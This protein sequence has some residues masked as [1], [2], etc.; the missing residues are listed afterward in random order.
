MDLLPG[1]LAAALGMACGRFLEVWGTT[2]DP[3]DAQDVAALAGLLEQEIASALSEA[4]EQE[5]ER[6]TG[7]W[8]TEFSDAMTRTIDEAST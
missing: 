4:I 5:V 6:R 8:V 2:F 1:T 7:A 3:A